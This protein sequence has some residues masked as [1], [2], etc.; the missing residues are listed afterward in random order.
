MTHSLP[1]FFRDNAR[2]ANFDEDHIKA[3]ASSAVA[4]VNP[5][6]FFSK[7]RIENMAEKVLN[8]IAYT[9]GPV[10]LDAI[11]ERAS[12][13]DH[14]RVVRDGVERREANGGQILGTIGFEPLEIVLYRDPTQLAVRE[15]FT[16][17]HELAHYLLRH[18]RYMR[19]ERCTEHDI[20]FGSQKLIEAEDVARMEWQANFLASCLLLPKQ[21]LLHRFSSELRSKNIQNKGFGPLFLDN[22]QV[23][24]ESFMTITT[25]LMFEFGV[26]R[27]AVKY[28]LQDMNMLVDARREMQSAFAG[29]NEMIGALS[30][31]RQLRRSGDVR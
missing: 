12:Q 4:L 28:R 27:S 9:E 22:Q 30:D 11:C 6:P 25:S 17:A 24:M 13:K 10:S 23:N 20:E 19:R 5:V 16:L 3:V 2:E 7:V 29:R 21:P 1:Q 31:H 18:G 15:R 8:A 26:S 14:L